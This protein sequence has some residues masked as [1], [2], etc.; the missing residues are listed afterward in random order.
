MQDRVLKKGELQRSAHLSPNF[1]LGSYLNK[2]NDT[3]RVNQTTLGHT[4]EGKITINFCKFLHN[5]FSGV[6]FEME[7]THINQRTVPIHPL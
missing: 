6:L 1:W 7:D 4:G 3:K 2:G 5:M